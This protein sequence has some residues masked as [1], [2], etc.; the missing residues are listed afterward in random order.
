VGIDSLVMGGHAV[1]YYGIDRNTIDFDL[2]TSIAKET[3]RESDWQDIALL[4]EILDDRCRAAIGATSDSLFNFLSSLR[5]RVKK[6]GSLLNN[7]II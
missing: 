7:A 5:S 4:E 3:E 6:K 1:R 2:V